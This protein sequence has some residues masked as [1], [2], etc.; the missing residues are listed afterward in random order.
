MPAEEVKHISM[1]YKLPQVY[2]G[3]NLLVWGYSTES[4]HEVDIEGT[5]ENEEW[6]HL[7]LILDY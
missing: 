7:V 6:K 2:L 4:D 5:K 3:G 1:Y